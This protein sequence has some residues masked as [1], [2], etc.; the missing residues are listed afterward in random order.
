MEAIPVE[1][2]HNTWTKLAITISGPH[3]TVYMNC[4]EVGTRRILDP[5]FSMDDPDLSMWLG[6]RG[7]DK[8]YF[9]VCI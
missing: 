7:P 8:T 2:E 3:V 4:E 9:K 5:D 6:Q 1:L